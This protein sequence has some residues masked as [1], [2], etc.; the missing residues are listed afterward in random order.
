MTM[1]HCVRL[2]A[3]RL[4]ALCCLCLPLAAQAIVTLGRDIELEGFVEAKNIL[5]PPFALVML[6]RNLS[7]RGVLIG[8]SSRN[9]S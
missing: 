7:N 9:E 3:G 4:A 2:N 1:K 6:G 8:S 5:R